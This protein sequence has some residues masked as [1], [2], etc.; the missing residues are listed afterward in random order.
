[1][2][3]ALAAGLTLA[4]W[5]A[6]DAR[7]QRALAE[8]RFELARHLADSLLYEVTD[9]IQDLAGSTKARELLLRRSLEY[10]GA[11]S[12][13]AASNPGLQRDLANAYMRAA[14]LQG[15]GGASNLGDPRAAR[16]SLNKATSLLEGALAS[17]PGSV[18]IRGD[19][20]KANRQFAFQGNDGQDRMA[21]AQRSLA[22]MEQLHRERPSDAKVLDDLQKS[23]F[24]MA[25]VLAG[26]SRYQESVGYYRRALANS[27]GSTPGNVA[28]I[29]KSLGAVLIQTGALDEAIREYK[30]A[31]AIDEQRV[32]EQPANG[33]AR[34]DLSYGY[35]DTGFIL[36]RMNQLPAAVEAYRKARAIRATMA[37]ADP[38]DARAATA[39]VSVEYRLGCTLARNGQRGEAVQAFHRSV[40]AGEAMVSSLPDRSVGTLALADACWNIGLCYR[41]VWPSCA[42]AQPWLLRGRSLYRALNKP[43]REVDESLAQ[44]SVSPAPAAR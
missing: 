24:A 8:R 30:A 33:R 6:R 5:Q 18:E 39:L 36:A 44:C 29:R 42:L 2:V 19:L 16:Q 41:K 27:A 32:R 28:L 22:L 38:R 11:L 43:T 10:L 20:A 1:M 23:E 34:L 25:R 15:V 35:S 12:S 17:A 26:Q 37:A 40:L 21:H 9:E 3:L 7:R 31:T 14:E 13:E 4:L